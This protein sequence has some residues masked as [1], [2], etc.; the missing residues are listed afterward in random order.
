MPTL[1]EA[2]RRRAEKHPERLLYTFL[3]DGEEEGERLSYGEHDLRARALAARLQFLGIRPGE[4]ALLVFPPGLDFVT[5]L[6]G[7]FYAGVVAVPAGISAI[8]GVPDARP[9]V[10]LTIEA[11]L[12]GLHG[13]T[14]L[15]VDGIGTG[16]AAGYR[17]PDV[18]S[19]D[20]ALPAVTHGDLV[21]QAYHL[22]RAF[23]ESE[24]EEAVL[25]G[26][27]PLDHGMGLLANVLLPLYARGRCVLMAPAA[28]LERP[29]RWLAAIS[30]YRATASGGPGFAYDLCVRRIGEEERAGLDLASWR[31]A[32]G[33]AEPARVE[34]LDRFAA[35]FAPA[36]FR[37]QAFHSAEDPAGLAI[38]GPLAVDLRT[39]WLGRELATV[40]PEADRRATLEAYLAGEAAR[41]LRLPAA[42]LDPGQP[43]AALGLDSLAAIELR[44]TL[45][46]DLGISPALAGLLEGLSV[47]DLAREILE[48]MQGE[49]LGETQGEMLG[50]TLGEKQR[51]TQRETLGETGGEPAGPVRHDPSYRHPE[52]SEGSGRGERR[53]TGR[54]AFVPTG[55]EPAELP[56]SSG[57]RGLWFL[58]RLAPE[59]GAYN[60]VSAARVRGELDAL[61]LERAL[62]ALVARH[63]ALR[64]TFPS[65][66]GEP[67]Q[68][69]ATPTE[70]GALDFQEV[71][72]AGWEEERAA[73]WLAVE[74]YRPFDLGGLG[75]LSPV[76][77]LRVRVLLRRPATEDFV[78]LAIHHL[79]SDFASLA[80]LVRELAALYA[81]ERGGPPAVWRRPA[82]TYGD[83]VRWQERL[84]ASP[85]GERQE[86]YW[87]ERLA[88]ELPVLELPA[89]RPRPPIQ[90][91]RGGAVS[92]RLAAAPSARLQALG[93][94]QGATLYM[95]L[96]AAF[97]TLL[98]RY[99]SEEDLLVGSPTAG[100]G[101]AALA[102]VVGYFVNP[103]V[104]RSDLAGD[105][106]F[107]ALL[108][109]VRR[110]VLDAFA[111]PDLPFPRLAE[112]LQ[113]VRDPSRSPVF[114]VLFVLQ[115]GQGDAAPLAA[116][117]L[118]ELGP[119]L[120]FDDLFLEPVALPERRA[121]YDLTLM[122]AELAG[123]GGELAASFEYNADLFDRATVE[124]LAA[125]FLTLLASI[126]SIAGIAGIAE[127]PGETLGALP[128]LAAPER[129]QLLEWS[130][131]AGEAAPGDRC[132]H[133]LVLAQ[134]ARTPAAEALVG[135]G[136][137][138]TYAELAA[139]AGRLAH[140]L[141]RLGVGPEVRVAICA[142]RTP[143]LVAGLL[144]IL[145]A[146]GA[147]V[148][149]ESTLP[150]ERLAF[151]L[152]SSGALLLLTEEDLTG[153]LEALAPAGTR[154]VRLDGPEESVGEAP[155]ATVLPSHPVPHPENLAYVIYT[156]GSTGEP[157]G[158]A[159][160]HASAV[161][162]VRWAGTVFPPA[163]LSGVLASTSI[164]F[165][166]SVFE[167]FVPLAWGGRVILAADALE[168]PRLPAAGEVTLVNTVPSVL[169][170]LL[171]S[172]PLPTSVRTV[173]LAGEPLP[174]SLVRQVRAARVLNLYGP[175]EDTT[176]ST[177]AEIDPRSP[178][179]LA[180]PAIGRP[181]PG[182]RVFLLDRWLQPVPVG[183]PGELFL[184]GA[185]LARGYL[186]RPDLTAERFVP[187]P[188]DSPGGLPGERL[189]RTGD[190]ARFRG[191]P[192]AG[193]LE[194]LGRLDYQV[195][196]RGFRIELQEIETVLSSHHQVAAAAVLAEGQGA[197]RRLVAYV[198]MP[199]PE[200]ADAE[201]R[202]FLRSR[203]PEYMVP[204]LFVVLEALPLTP[205]G[206]VDR[207]SLARL[208]AGGASL[209]AGRAPRGAIE[210]TLAAIWR[211]LLGTEEVTAESSFFDLGGHSLLATRL[212][213]RVQTAFG[214]DLPLPSLFA[215]PTL[216]GFAARLGASV[217]LPL[218]ADA[219]VSPPPRARL[220][221][222]APRPLSFSQ[223]RLWFLHQ[224]E[225]ESP[226]YNMPAAVRLRGALDSPALAR[227]L[228]EIVARHEALRTRFVLSRLVL[229]E[230]EPLQAPA[231]PAPFVL[232][233]ASLAA[234]PVPTRE[235]E[236]RRL[237][238]EEARLPFVD[239]ARSAPCRF[240]L[241]DLALDDHLLLLTFHHLVADGWS[242]GIFVREL[243]VLYESLSAGR[244]SPLPALALQYADWAVWQ[245]RWAAGEGE[246]EW[247]LARLAG[248][249]PDAPLPA[250]RPR[251]PSRS[252]RGAVRSTALPASLRA[253]LAALAREERATLFMALSAGFLALLSRWTGADDLRIGTPV[254]NR[255]APEAEETIGLF[256]NTVVLRGDLSGRPS[257]R[258]LLA[259]T[260][261]EVLGAYSHQD[262]PFERL[263]EALPGRRS[264]FQAV[265]NLEEP[266][267]ETA[268]LPG[269]TLERI[270]TASGTAKFDWTL[271]VSRSRAG[272]G[273]SVEYATDLFDGTTVERF[274]AGFARLLSAAVAAPEMPLAE[275]DLLSAA[276]RHQLVAE[277]NDTA[278]PLAD[279]SLGALFLR[280]VG[281]QPDAVALSY[282]EE[283]VSYGE[284]AR[285][286]GAL[287][288]RLREIGVGPE[289]TVGLEMERSIELIVGILGVVRAGG[290]YVPL[291]PGYPR[292]RLDW[293]VRDSGAVVVLGRGAGGSCGPAPSGASRSQAPVLGP[294]RP[295][296]SVEPIPGRS[297]EPEG[298]DQLAYV[299][300]TSGST[301]IPKGVAVSQRAV[302]R[303]VLGT[304]YVRLSGTDWI[305]QASTPSFDAA[306]FEIWGALLHGSRLVVFPP[307]ALS[308]AEVGGEVRRS[309][310]T[311]LWLTAGL[312]HQMVESRLDDLAG[313]RQLLAGGDVLSSDHVSRIRQAFP[314][315][316][317][318][319]GYGPTEG[320]TFTA[321][322]PV[323]EMD[324]LGPVPVG[325]PISNSTVVVLDR[326]MRPVPLG[327]A[328]ELCAGGRGLARGY[329]GDPARTAERFVP[330]VEANSPGARLYR[331]G[332]RAWLRADGR[333]DF[334]GRL[335]RQVKIRGFRIE[336]GEVETALA[337]HP[338]LLAAAVDVRPEP[339]GGKRLVAWV[340]GKVG[341]LPAA[342]LRRFLL[343][344]IPQSSVPS[345]FVFLPELPLTS[346]G[347]VDRRALP[348][349]GEAGAAEPLGDWIAPRAPFEE[350]LAA[351]W[352]EV[353]GRERVGVTEDFFDLGG[354]SLL[355]TR[356]AT[357]A[358]AAFG[359][360][361]PLR[362][363]FEA[364]TVAAL[365]ARIEARL[366][367]DAV[368][369]A[370]AGEAPPLTPI[371]R[372]GA[373]PLSFAQERL[374]FLD[375]LEPES[376]F[377][378]ISGAVRLVGALAVPALAGSLAAVVARQESLRTT[379]AVEDGEPVQRIAPPGPFPVPRVDLSSLPEARREGE[380][381]R[382]AAAAAARP[383]DL[384]R[385][386]LLRTALL[387]LR[388]AEHVLVLVVHHIVADGW[389]M[390]VLLREVI[391]AYGALAAGQPPRLPALPLQYA[392]FAA[393]QRRF[394]SGAGLARQ[395]AWWRAALAGVPEVLALP[396]DRKRPPR[397][398]FAGGEVRSVLPAATR[399]SLTALARRE[400]ASLF[401]VLLAAFEVLLSRHSGQEDLT[402]GTPIAGR[403]SR[404]IEGL[405]GFFVNTVVLRAD[406]AGDPPFTGLL[407]RVR[408]AALDAYAHAEVPFEK[409]VAE[410]APRRDASH[411]PLFQV[412][413]SFEDLATGSGIKSLPGLAI[414]PLAIPDTTAKFDLS[415]ILRT[416]DGALHLS[417]S[418]ARALFDRTTLAR[419]AGHF[420]ILIAGLL[421]DPGRP[422]S[423]LP[424]LT[425]AEFR[426]VEGEWN[427]TEVD[428][429][430]D[431]CFHAL[432]SRQAGR[433]PD[434]VALE[435]ESE[436]HTYLELDARSNQLAHHLAALGVRPEVRVAVF[437]PRTPQAMLSL[438]ALW[439]AGG[440]YLPLPAGSPLDHLAFLLDESAPGVILTREDRLGRLPASALERTR[441]VSVDADREAIA[442][443]P[444]TPPAA[445]VG[446]DQLANLFYTSGSTGR[447]KGVMI[448]HRNLVNFLLAYV[449]DVRLHPGD[450]FLA[451]TQATFDPSLLE[452]FTPL[453]SGA[454][455]IVVSEERVQD[456]PALTSVLRDATAL[457]GVPSFYRQ[458][459][460]HLEETG[461]AA[462]W[463]QMRSVTVGGESS[464]TDLLQ[465]L[466][467]VFPRAELRNS[468]GP[469]EA[470]ILCTAYPAH[471]EGLRGDVI[472]RPQAN[473]TVRLLDRA[474]HPVPIGV[475]GEI[476]IGGLGI[477]RGYFERP[478][479]TAERF[480]PGRDGRGFRTGDLARY[481][482]DGNVL[483][484]GRLDNQVKIRGQRIELGEIEAT[485]SLHPAVAD[486][487][488]V[489]REEAGGKRLVAYLVPASGATLDVSEL[490][491]LA[492]LRLPAAMLPA[493]F[494][495]LPSLPQTSHGKLD[496]DALPAPE[497][498]RRETARAAPRN[499]LERAIA[500]VWREI[501]GPERADE[502]GIDDNFFELGGDSLLLLRLRSRLQAVVGRDVPVVTLF[503]FAT[504]RAFAESLPAK[505]GA[506]S[507][508]A[509]PEEEPE[510][511]GQNRREAL[512]R[513]QEIRGRRRR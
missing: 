366:R 250:D 309:G 490:R 7:C 55:E 209:R 90:T 74:G 188:F 142:R 125:N 482:P 411:S 268:R 313:V 182:T 275:I 297:E 436:H 266:L 437:L 106:P 11:L 284:L 137:R 108:G 406:L 113:P 466:H 254:A 255:R 469:T 267:L 476:W 225:P 208:D 488:V 244:P 165:D 504:I 158:V 99:T 286:S 126:A 50:E 202:L 200:V 507:A 85:E 358:R 60:I 190:L 195:K 456:F 430:C 422:L 420:E 323:G 223:R 441:V 299:I 119:R 287:A 150:D 131:E 253:G 506:A 104:L 485:L 398:S 214:V 270:E 277:W 49:M 102:D 42:R 251:P 433:A 69:V 84:L 160:S 341:E 111:H 173:N 197:D 364:P 349:P 301:G 322:H 112:E 187:D 382:L 405:L 170:E 87:R 387:Q 207:R 206:K 481:L 256:V 462:G 356:V 355:A 502:V 419:M 451:W 496:R 353:L 248:D 372:E 499:D 29:R 510:D 307:G 385:G 407:A 410:L 101:A 329:W 278:V 423:Q 311:V 177:F 392:D 331:T 6:F 176:Y 480:T 290:A 129:M 77:L 56:L 98:Y 81:E 172:G 338:G 445:S 374:W 3:V 429:G 513:L 354:H 495:L 155:P 351:I 2:S 30:R 512:A 26:W 36:G 424:L 350:V 282:G 493:A 73:A 473:M 325:R 224:L 168:L 23:F 312:F 376:P 378:N 183:V 218:A 40:E 465:A 198:A 184:G 320:T 66:E 435:M 302:Q 79:V 344:K 162:L 283:Q 264:L 37:R 348:E 171:R 368:G 261:D 487:A 409:L 61:A 391:A 179:S 276:A 434:A 427:D 370:D 103:L 116:F 317:L 363:L 89:D 426:Q 153:R 446:S 136:E 304:N 491:A 448:E 12:P 294:A 152:R 16:E 48:T 134:A 300:Y 194:Y 232:P 288:L 212:L 310:V 384:A 10:T 178:V 148:P 127:R 393:W 175:S 13:G 211:D 293:M 233:R 189:Y 76:P 470:T 243:S 54:S 34:T 444:R 472:G 425:A 336:P 65:V 501:L 161:A 239:L 440:V 227:S 247:W 222:G 92:V 340:V 494:V 377:Y 273:V 124:R 439:K 145:A 460:L 509:A 133:E 373:L 97:Q 357:R 305:A 359:V 314:E 122:A 226:A 245:R 196:V 271:T 497:R 324:L 180:S 402:V 45:E 83:F 21:L 75:G 401:M 5:A 383:F 453:L 139:R 8:I 220:E 140:R 492:A 118:G 229:P 463:E 367:S 58:S 203:L 147:Y 128:L 249:L 335:D 215:A 380:V 238:D 400:G 237:A 39:P 362:E 412:L 146:G 332:D 339:G 120:A 105:P 483:F 53:S 228:G 438:L 399:D 67:L 347:K 86:R 395:L 484:L 135:R 500:A 281:R 123:R 94:R 164:G 96:L 35:A 334:L 442:R 390:E 121:Q 117:A 141:R 295:H 508:P 379:F 25:V 333:I 361:L 258:A 138:L 431:A 415:F 246:L 259:R 458:V 109:R 489:A 15:A 306:T 454:K 4:R 478:D 1:V 263:V 20:L 404:E 360:D 9:R 14:L 32:H 498:P 46:T 289:V 408:G 91:D 330:S 257:F 475:P 213:A 467:R 414:L 88:G 41:R 274:L 18:R 417:W 394:L 371:P 78:L 479:L 70:W 28:F 95:T 269:L 369:A 51:E 443:A 205:N 174:G 181:L 80:I 375:Q 114:Q 217:A 327:V 234:L 33:G 457:D 292:E 321:C 343:E 326:E 149:M 166:L 403:G 169:A 464:S 365:A 63:G 418:Y 319:N 316:R 260:R 486:V 298:M 17:P 43:L 52:R 22:R 132:L 337:A 115:P 468:Y 167:L 505:P 389:S 157:K 219:A 240:R 159:I 163:D 59:S 477:G 279:E 68:R 421:A 262:L 291:D 185:G 107:T 191:A 38:D 199:S 345:A 272:L 413:L 386:P 432:F 72:A 388:P 459:A 241:V 296:S 151:L 455:V 236:A 461:Q 280:Q 352:A 82:A 242:L 154:V 93:R 71:D 303:L 449:A 397:Q 110:T 471:A 144:G 342:E 230:D 210:E 62:R 231:P 308:L 511:R 130:A 428:F 416:V 328:G 318:I 450:V 221:P 396:A 447:P 315:C 252:G 47:R 346:Q 192:E 44:Q 381:L 31:V 201:L 452:W 57:Q 265:F 503:Q 100:R 235:A 474:G 216:A 186:G 143:D 24:E 19:R 27:L 193:Q 156:S 64:T 204:A 285:R